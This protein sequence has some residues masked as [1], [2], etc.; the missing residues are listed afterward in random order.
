MSVNPCA[1]QVLVLVFHVSL[2]LAVRDGTGAIIEGSE[3]RTL[4]PLAC[5]QNLALIWALF[6]GLFFF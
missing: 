1:R 6:K 3:V 4:P 5:V 2:V